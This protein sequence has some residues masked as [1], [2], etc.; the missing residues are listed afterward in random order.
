MSPGGFRATPNADGRISM[1]LTG[2][3]G[4]FRGRMAY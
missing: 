4:R 2:T 1:T 3:A